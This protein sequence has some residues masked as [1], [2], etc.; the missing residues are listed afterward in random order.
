ME[1]APYSNQRIRGFLV[2]VMFINGA[3]RNLSNL[4]KALTHG[5]D[6]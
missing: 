1:E 5:N 4:N 3:E 6:Q 2:A